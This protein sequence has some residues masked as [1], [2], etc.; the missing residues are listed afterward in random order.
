MR[1]KLWNL[2]DKARFEYCYYEECR[3]RLLFWRSAVRSAKIAAL[4]ALA[5]G[6]AAGIA[7]LHGPGFAAQAVA[8]GAWTALT[9]CE[10]P[11]RDKLGAL[12]YALPEM[13]ARLRRL[14]GDWHKVN[15]VYEYKEKD[16]AKMF[17]THMGRL[18]AISEKYLD[19][20]NLPRSKKLAARASEIAAVYANK[21]S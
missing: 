19:G 1:E 3:A 20:L 16:V 17:A 15:G 7:G 14:H 18:E 13:S 4:V 11:L 2:L 12:G 21:L 10:Q 6:I 8:L 9:A 5:G